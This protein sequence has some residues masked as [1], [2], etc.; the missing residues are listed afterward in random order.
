MTLNAHLKFPLV[1]QSH[2]RWW[3]RVYPKVRFLDYWVAWVVGVVD[4][5]PTFWR[6]V[7]RF[8]RI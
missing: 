3:L 6:N 8:P 1:Q 7:P 2:G 5:H 4:L